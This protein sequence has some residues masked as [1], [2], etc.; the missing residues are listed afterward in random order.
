MHILSCDLAGDDCG[1]ISHDPDLRPVIAGSTATVQFHVSD[2]L[3]QSEGIFID[4][5]LHRNRT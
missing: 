4:G 1:I 5:I 2:V 3:Y